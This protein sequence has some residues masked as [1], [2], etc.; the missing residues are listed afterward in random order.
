MDVTAKLF[1]N[2]C[3]QAVRIPK[4]LQF[5]GVDRVT[6]RKDGDALILTPVRRDWQSF[7]EEAPQADDDFMIDRHALFDAS[8]VNL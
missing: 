3:S 1:D 7:A 2:G 8:R 4:A 6:L 5:R